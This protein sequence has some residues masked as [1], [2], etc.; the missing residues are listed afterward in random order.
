MI[1]GPYENIDEWKKRVASSTHILPTDVL[2][3]SEP[4]TLYTGESFVRACLVPNNGAEEWKSI[5]IGYYEMNSN[6]GWY[7]P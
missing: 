4:N 7:Y 2:R 5:L 1:K 3:Y 6:V